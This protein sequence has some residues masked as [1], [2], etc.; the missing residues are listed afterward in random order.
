MLQQVERTIKKIEV[1]AEQVKSSSRRNYNP[2]EWDSK[3]NWYASFHECKFYFDEEKNEYLAIYRVEE[4]SPRFVQ[5]IMYSSILSGAGFHNGFISDTVIIF[6]K[7]NH[8]L[9][10]ENSNENRKVL[11]ENSKN[12]SSIFYWN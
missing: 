11:S 5:P 4:N 2:R 12:N 7:Y 9:S 1:T 8:G 6:Y 3:V 10:I